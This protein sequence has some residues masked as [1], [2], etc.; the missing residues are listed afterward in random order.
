VEEL[1]QVGEGEELA[2]D[3][4][5]GE[6]EAEGT[7]PV[8][9]AGVGVEVGVGR[10]D[11]AVEER[12]ALGVAAGRTRRPRRPRRTRCRGEEGLADL[13]VG[14]VDRRALAEAELLAKRHL[15]LGL[16]LVRG[17]LDRPDVGDQL[18]DLLGGERAAALGA[19]AGIGVPGRP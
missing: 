1:D 17:E 14:V 10:L 11:G 15:D 5:A 7:R 6:G 16:G 8:R 9:V 4:A 12:G 3:D 19:P 2:R 18:V 13:G